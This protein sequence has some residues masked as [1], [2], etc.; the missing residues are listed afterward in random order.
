[1]TRTI[2]VSDAQRDLVKD[3]ILVTGAPRSGTTLVGKIVGSFAGLEYQFEPPTFYMISS[4]YAAGKLSLEAASAL[5]AVYLSEDLFL[6]SVQGRRANLR[7]TDDSLILNRLSWAELNERWSG[8]ETRGEAIR[9]ASERGL[10]LAVKMPNVLDGMELFEAAIPD[11]LVV[12][13][14][15]DGVDVVRS[16]VRKGWVT[17]EGLRHDLWPYVGRGDGARTPYW[18]PEELAD[19]WLGGTPETRA[20]ILWSYHA[21]RGLDHF[22][23]RG[24]AA[25]RVVRYE[26]LLGDPR[27]TVR[28]LAEELGHEVTTAT[29]RH[30]ES[31]RSPR[32]SAGQE[33]DLL[34]SVPESLAARFRETN[35]AWG[36]A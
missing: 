18:V 5:L 6:E 31:I 29:R 13:V 25:A 4:L 17:D 3:T 30:V 24:G 28:T 12:L 36:Y 23:A 7:P 22:R 33:G 9:W 2:E 21:R 16:I 35:A 26:E 11:L 34:R 10:R 14:V 8:I 32:R 20:C 19:A 15:R 1:M 27:E